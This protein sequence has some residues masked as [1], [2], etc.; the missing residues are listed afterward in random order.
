MKYNATIRTPGTYLVLHDNGEG[1]S[2]EPCGTLVDAIRYA[3]KECYGGSPFI[4]R[5]V[6]ISA[7]VEEPAK[8]LTAK[9]LVDV[10]SEVMR[11]ELRQR[12]M[13]MDC[14][15]SHASGW[16]PVG[17]TR[18]RCSDCNEKRQEK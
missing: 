11:K 7:H 14:G 17:K 18:I 13:C 15:T 2:A 6:D 5:V 8:P 10:D 16:F 3:V 1:L 9:A 12:S 4:V